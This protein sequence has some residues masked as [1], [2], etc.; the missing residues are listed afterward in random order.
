MFGKYCN[1]IN[2]IVISISA[3]L[4]SAL[5]AS[6]GAGG[7]AFVSE[8]EA[9]DGAARNET[10]DVLVRSAQD[11]G[12]HPLDVIPDPEIEAGI[13]PVDDLPDLPEDSGASEKR[14]VSYAKNFMINLPYAGYWIDVLKY[15]W[16][17]SGGVISE[18][19][20]PNSVR[21]TSSSASSKAW[22]EY[23]F[24]TAGGGVVKKID[25]YG[26][27][28][29]LSVFLYNWVAGHYEFIGTYSLTSGPIQLAIAPQY[30]SPNY[31]LRL[32]LVQEATASSKIDRIHSYVD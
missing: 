14:G 1:W 26:S 18:G 29:K 27:G 10:L 13:P 11:E 32:R 19:Y 23:R 8:P 16:K 3:I 21:L 17:G 9:G 28:N 2:S 24:T 4:M 6:C 5:M 20:K 30:T 12:I 7:A 15:G 31:E 25:I 22:I